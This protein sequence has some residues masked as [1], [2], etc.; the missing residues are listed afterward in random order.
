MKGKTM[1]K[2]YE[3]GYG[4]PPKKYQFKKGQSGNKKGRPK[5]SKNTYVLLDEILSQTIPITENGKLI[6]IS[7]RNAVLIQ[8]VNKA[9]KGDLKATNALLPH[10]LMADAKEEDKEKI[11]SALNRDDE[12]IISNYLKRFADFNEIKGENNNE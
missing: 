8:L 5:N 11:M 7:K 2:E 12:K 6:H 3:V 4:K 9:I 1:D 10:M